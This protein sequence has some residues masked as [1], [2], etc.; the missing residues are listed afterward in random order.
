MIENQ[1][2]RPVLIRWVPW[3]DSDS[4]KACIF[5]GGKCYAHYNQERCR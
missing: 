4:A 1:K 5:W 2:N 3:P